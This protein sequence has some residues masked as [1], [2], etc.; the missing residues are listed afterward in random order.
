MVPYDSFFQT[1][2]YSSAFV[3]VLVAFQLSPGTYGNNSFL[4]FIINIFQIIYSVDCNNA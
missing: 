2:E 4:L 1:K 3:G